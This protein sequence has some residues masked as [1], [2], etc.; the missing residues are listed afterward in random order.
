MDAKFSFL[1]GVLQE[2]VYIDQPQGY[3]KKNEE[4]KVYRLKKALYGLKQ[5]LRAWYSRIDNYFKKMGFK[6]CPFEN[7]LYI[8]E[9]KGNILIIG[10]YVDDLIF[11]GNNHYE[12][13]EFRKNMM[14]EFEMTDLGLLHYFLGIEVK[15]DENGIF[16]SREKY[17]R[18]LMKKFRMEDVKPSSTSIEAK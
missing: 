8:K 18:D 11:T 2:E 15:Q 9:N 1:N 14:Q 10:L 17:A 13:E 16:I 6:R 3:V 7:T 4:N 12:I 5:A